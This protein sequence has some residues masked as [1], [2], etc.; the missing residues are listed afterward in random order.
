M[1][2]QIKSTVRTFSGA[3]EIQRHHLQVGAKGCVITV[4]DDNPAVTF[5]VATCPS[6]ANFTGTANTLISPPFP[7][8]ANNSVPT[9]AEYNNIK[10]GNGAVFS[11]TNPFDSQYG[12][13]TD[14]VIR[15]SAAGKLVV[16]ELV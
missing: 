10:R 13:L 15:I 7:P 6:N 8:E 14:I 16:E 1:P 9:T 5:E 12:Y 2:N 11:V 3:A 4:H